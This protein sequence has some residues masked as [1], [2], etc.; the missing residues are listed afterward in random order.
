MIE[1]NIDYY[2][3]HD[4][5]QIKD[6]LKTATL[7]KLYNTLE[8]ESKNFLVEG[9]CNDRCG[10]KLNGD[11]NEGLQLLNL[12]KGIC[13]IISKV[14]E[15]DGF[16]RGSSC[17]VSFFYFSI[18]LYEHV[19]KIKAQNDQ[20][21][22]FYA[23]LKSF[24]QTKKSELDNSSI[25]NFNEDKNN[26]MD[27]KY[28]LEFLRIYEDIEEKISGNDNLNVKLYCKHI[29]YFFQYYNKIKENCNNTPEP[30]FCNMISM[31]K[32]TFITTKY[33]EKI[34]EKCKYEP[35]SCNNNILLFLFLYYH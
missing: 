21:N 15:F 4:K 27:T 20:I 13:N 11:S 34:Y 23:A 12:C 6:L 8:Q 7:Y 30:L 31:Y 33:I 24:M 19:Q 9:S 29:K 14:R 5:T 1:P 17:R 35:I 26:F 10:E 32:T 28:L 18:W 16:C 3:D 25:I 22:N 2:Q